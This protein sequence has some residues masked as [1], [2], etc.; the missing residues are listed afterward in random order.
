VAPRSLFAAGEYRIRLLGG[1]G[2]VTEAKDG[3]HV[4]VERPLGFVFVKLDPA[5]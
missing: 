3:F 2:E 1:E 5:H 4:T